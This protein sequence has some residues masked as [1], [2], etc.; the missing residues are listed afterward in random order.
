MSSYPPPPL[1]FCGFEKI[2]FMRKSLPHII[3]LAS[4]PKPPISNLIS[5]RTLATHVE[6]KPSTIVHTLPD[7]D[8]ATLTLYCMKNAASVCVRTLVLYLMAM[9]VTI[10]DNSF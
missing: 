1:S 8:T 3:I 6:K 5:Y 9:P 10:T 4:Q 7:Y 2:F